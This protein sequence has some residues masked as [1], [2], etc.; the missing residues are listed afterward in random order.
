MKREKGIWYE[1][2]IKNSWI[3]EYPE[4]SAFFQLKKTAQ[5]CP[6]LKSLEFQSKSLNFDSLI[7]NIEKLAKALSCYGIKKGDIVALAVD[8][9]PQMIVALLGIIKSGAAY[10]PLDLQ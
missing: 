8:R 4:C 5:N 6:D 10:L 3:D 7:R 9:S 2:R 1:H